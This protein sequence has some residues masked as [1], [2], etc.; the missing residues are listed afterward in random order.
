MDEIVIRG[1]REHNL[2]NVDVT[3]PRHRFIVVTGL[4]GSGKSSLA[5]NTLYAEGQRRFVESLSAYARQFLG[6][7]E[8]PDVDEITGLSPTILIDQKATSRNPRS[9][10]GTV[11]EIYDYLRL[12]YARIGQPHCP[13]CDRAVSAQS[14]EQM[15][16]RILER[17]DG[18]RIQL[19]A[20]LIQGRKGEYQRLFEEIG[21]EGYARL[22]VDGAFRELTEFVGADRAELDKRR[23]HTIEVVVD[24]LILKPDLRRRLTDSVETTLRL[25]KGLLRLLVEEQGSWQ[26][27]TVSE[28]LACVHCDISLQ[29]LEPRLFSFNSPYGACTVCG[30]LGVKVEIDPEKVI[31]DKTKSI[32]EGAIVPWSKAIGTGR[33]PS[34]NPYYRQ[35]VE[36]LLRERKVKATTPIEKLPPDL[37]QTILYG[38]DQRQT[39]S[40]TSRG[41]HV[42]TYET[43]FEG[44]VTNLQ[45]RY[46]ETNSAYV[47]EDIE[48]YMSATVCGGCK[49]ARLKPEAL[50]VRVGDLGIDALT[51]LPI[52]DLDPFFQHLH[53]SARDTQIATRILKEI[54]SRL[55]FLVDVGL[56]YL[57]LGRSAT[58]LSGG[59]AQRIRL[60]T[61]IGSALVGV[62]YVLDEPSIG[63]HQRDNDR[64]IATLKRLRDLGN[65]L[66]V[67]EHDEDTMRAAD[68]IVD[69][70]P[71]AGRAG[72]EILAVG[73]IATIEAHPDS[74][75]GAYLSGRRSIPVPQQR[76]TA[77][78]WVTIANARANNLQG[79]TLEVPLGLFTAVTGVSGS[80]K[81]TLVH[82]VLVRALTQRLRTGS[83]GRTSNEPRSDS[84]T[85]ES[86][87]NDMDSQASYG[88]V[89]G[90]SALDR[91]IVIDQSPIGRT[92]RSN[93]ATYTGVFDLIRELFTNVPEAKVRGYTA[94]RFSFNVKGGRC[95]TCQGEGLVTIEMHFLPNVEVECDACHGKRYNA[96]T[97]EITYKGATI[98][99]VL[100]MPVSEARDFF[101]AIPRINTRLTT[102]IDVGLG[103]ITLGQPATQLSGGEAQRVKLATELAKRATGRTLYVLDE[104]TTGLHF[105]DIHKLLEVLHRLVELGNSVIVI[106][107]NL[108]VIKTADWLI[109]LGPEGGSRGG[110]IVATGTPES[111]AAMPNSFT[112]KYLRPVLAD[113]RLTQRQLVAA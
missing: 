42:W 102:L 98:A 66:V 57:T 91:L 22:R 105:A 106:E 53:L 29:P 70:G 24:R 44:V 76:R 1:A 87:F 95:E 80:G 18:T 30:G 47:R 27:T 73:P 9:T 107:H 26:E 40:Y 52:E 35:Q 43:A 111:V 12:L 92:P 86:A 3:L 99:D 49:G 108:D 88:R 41:G 46:T 17:P 13:N 16:D 84:S 15:V 36:K 74:L 104:P 19:L 8:K 72:G 51:H 68:I 109:D 50:A 6:Q 101:A 85:F 110:T 96:Q 45:R 28:A 81:S 20:P 37:L 10:V 67:I 21:K 78:G 77:R 75:T 113:P 55:T 103:Y 83:G 32:D 100:A 82:R 112:G 39:F 34:M 93:P 65:T 56:G 33:F 7:M 64:L 5:V 94:G 25:G 97:L 90:T 60:A 4:S 38:T 63:L 62:L 54:R 23:K 14:A 89:S 69:V 79:V 2:K 48:R 31:P 71:G 61:Q 58:T 59:E 11:T